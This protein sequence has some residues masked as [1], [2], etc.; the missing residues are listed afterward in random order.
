MN[1]GMKELKEPQENEKQGKWKPNQI[2]RKMT[3]Q[4]LDEWNAM[5]ERKGWLCLGMDSSLQRE[6][7]NLKE[8]KMLSLIHI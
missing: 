8:P 7:P 1:A 4:I 5:G 6:M 3:A 2:A